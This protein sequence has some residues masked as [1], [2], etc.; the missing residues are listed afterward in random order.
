MRL[1]VLRDRFSLHRRKIVALSCVLAAWFASPVPASAVAIT[2]EAPTTVVQGQSFDVNFIVDDLLGSLLTAFKFSIEFDNLALAYNGDAAL[3]PAVDDS[4]FVPPVY[5]AEH[6]TIV[7]DILGL[8][9]TPLS[10]GTL[11]AHASFT[12]STAF[13]GETSI[14]A[15]FGFTQ[16]DFLLNQSGLDLI[17]GEDARDGD[18][19]RFLG[20]VNVVA[21][22]TTVPEPGT[23]L[24]LST[25]LGASVFAS[26]RRQRRGL[27][28]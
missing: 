24:L 4:G 3:G 15:L 5:S 21:P 2:V 16:G 26:R 12:A 27:R 1:F 7:P 28:D 25:G 10:D 6:P 9:L 17:F 14:F 13:T 18:Q 19:V 8:P 22:P 23:L 11:L 20:S